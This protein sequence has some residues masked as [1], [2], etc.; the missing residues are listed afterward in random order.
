MPTKFLILRF[1]SIGD[2]VLTTPVVRC[3]KQQY[4]N[5]ETHYFTKPAFAGILQPNP[6]I[7]T[8]HVLDEPLWR[9]TLKLKQ[10]GFDYVIDLHNN[11]RTRIIKTILDV[12]AFS[13]DKVNLEKWQLVKFGINILPTVH[14]VDRYLNTLQ[15]FGVTNDGAGLDFFMDTNTSFP[16]SLNYLNEK[17]FVAMAIGAQHATKRLPTEKLIALCN[18]ISKPILLLGGKDDIE[19]GKQIT[20][21][22]PHA[23]SL[24]GEL[25]LQQSAL[26]VKLS[27]VL[28]THDTGLMH[29][30]TALQ[31]PTISI[32]GNTVPAFGMYPYYGKNQVNHQIF[33]VT[34]LS[35]RPCSKIGHNSCPK[36]HFNCMQQQPITC[37]AHAVNQL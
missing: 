11:L 33:E 13:F 25:S 3:L 37:I 22:V 24:C 29:I 34:N 2:I 4:P 10:L 19:T 35:C 27:Q 16:E 12:P 31:K 17:P 14:V 26:I 5:A 18:Q 23:Q 30:A 9:K 6:Y 1:S 36:T 8:V 21:Q 15:N 7:N 28:I 32:W 20:A